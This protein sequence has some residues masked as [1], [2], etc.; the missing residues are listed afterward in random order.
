MKIFLK[1]AIVLIM[2]APGFI[3]KGYRAIGGADPK[4]NSTS[5]QNSICSDYAHCAGQEHSTCVNA[6]GFTQDVYC[7][8]Q[9]GAVGCQQS[10]GGHRNAESQG[11]CTK[12]T[13]NS[14]GYFE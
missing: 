8:D 9:V 1:F 3:D 13:E 6:A 10:C 11:N 4:C 12:P 5:V 2:V 14:T 7:K